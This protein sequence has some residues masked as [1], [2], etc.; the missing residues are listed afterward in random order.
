MSFAARVQD[1]REANPGCLV[2]GAITTTQR[3]SKGV[4]ALAE[5]FDVTLQRVTSAHEFA[6]LYKTRV[7]PEPLRLIDI[8]EAELIPSVS[9]KNRCTA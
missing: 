3:H 4:G 1:I 6:F 2:K 5:Y 8:V 9:T 7:A